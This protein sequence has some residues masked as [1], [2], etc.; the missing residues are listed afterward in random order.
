MPGYILD[1]GATITC[2]HGGRVT[3]APRATRVVLGGSPPLL[4]DDTASIAGCPFN[5]SGAPS[6]CLSVQ[7]VMPA[8]RVD[9]RVLAGPAVDLG[10]AVHERRERPAGHGAR[11]RLPDEGAG[12][13]D[14]RRG[15]RT[16]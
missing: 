9:G 2:P 7:W 1:A 5:V 10:R 14:R 11:Q 8:V 12:A 15:T 16:G 6:P 13:N 3:V 4:V